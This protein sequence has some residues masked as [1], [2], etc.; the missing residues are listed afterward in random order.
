M[1]NY[2][3]ILTALNACIGTA[4]LAE[5]RSIH[6]N[7]M[8]EFKELGRSRQWELKIPVP[9]EGGFTLDFDNPVNSKKGL[10]VHL[11]VSET[12]SRKINT[13]GVQSQRYRIW[14]TTTMDQGGARS[15]EQNVY[16]FKAGGTSFS[17]ASEIYSAHVRCAFRE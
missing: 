9:Q 6:C 12:S 15:P 3:F 13:I 1:K 4:A 17:E 8:E 5:N 2:F 16:A 10:K 14:S 11:H 7:V